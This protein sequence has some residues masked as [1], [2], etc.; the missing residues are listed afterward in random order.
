MF[1]TSVQPPP[2][3]RFTFPPDTGRMGDSARHAE[4]GT[5]AALLAACYDDVR[6]IARAIL[7]RDGMAR[8]I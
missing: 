7:A 6:R 2:L 3:T 4:A 5:P 1:G 8:V